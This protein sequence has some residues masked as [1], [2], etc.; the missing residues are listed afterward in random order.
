MSADI[1][2]NAGWMARQLREAASR[3]AR[4]AH[5]GEGALSRYAGLAV[6]AA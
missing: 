5:F 4:V 3:G 1:K 6:F 2:Q